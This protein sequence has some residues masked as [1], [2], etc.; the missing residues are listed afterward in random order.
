MGPLWGAL[1]ILL[2][3]DVTRIQRDSVENDALLRRLVALGGATQASC[4]PAG[5]LLRLFCQNNLARSQGVACR[6]CERVDEGNG[7]ALRAALRMGSALID[8][9]DAF[10]QQRTVFL[11]KSVL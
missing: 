4:G 2:D 10:V 11:L 8:V 3:G 5:R 6:I 1:A 7:R 9:C